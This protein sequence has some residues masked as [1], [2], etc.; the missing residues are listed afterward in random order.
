MGGECL[1]RRQGPQDAVHHREQVFVFDSD[2]REGRE[3]GEVAQSYF[4]L[5]EM[6]WMA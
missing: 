5:E 4:Q 1:F 6:A 2:D 3:S